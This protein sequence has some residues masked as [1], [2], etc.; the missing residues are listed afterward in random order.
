MTEGFRWYVVNV[1][2]GFEKKVAE[3]I[4]EQAAKK[5]L[6]EQIDSVLV[7]TEEVVEIKKGAKVTSERQFFP[8]YI[9][10]KMKLSDEIWHLI[11]HT[12]KV[13]GFLGARGKPVPVSQTEVDRVLAQVQEGIEKPK[14]SITF[15]IGEQVRVCEGPFSSFNGVVEEVDDEKQRVKVAV[16]IFGRSTPIDLDFIQVEKM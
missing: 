13:S 1:Y 4:Q 3:H 2:S 8:G 11:R 12:P 7:P 16:S 10:V 5:G 15:E 14:S 9:L 6:A